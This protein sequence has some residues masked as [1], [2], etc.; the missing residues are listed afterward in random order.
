[1][2][3]MISKI[4]LM[5]RKQN[6]LKHFSFF[7]NFLSVVFLRILQRVFGLVSMYFLLK[8]LSPELYGQYQFILTAVTLFTFFAL[9]G[10]G[11]AIVQ[12]VARGYPGTYKVLQFYSFLS[13]LVG[14]V[15]LMFFSIWYYSS[16]QDANI[17]HGFIL[18]ALLFPFSKGLLQWRSYKTGKKLFPSLVFWEGITSFLINAG[19]IVGVFLVPGNYIVPLLVVFIIPGLINI[20]KTYERL[21]YLKGDNTCEEGSL[22]YSIQTTIYSFPTLLATHIEKILLFFFLSPSALAVFVL[23]QKIPELFRNLFQDLG[24]VLAPYLAERKSYSLKLDKALKLFALVAGLITIVISFTI[25]PWLFRLLFDP[26]YYEAIPYMIAMMISVVLGVH[27]N[28]RYR[29]IRSQMDSKSIRDISLI[30]ALTRILVA[31]ICIPLYGLYGA[32]ISIFVQQLFFIIAVN[33]VINKKY[34]IS[35]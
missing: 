2:R 7:K 35:S 19:I 16:E 24:A 6:C 3:K 9:S 15:I 18:A 23:A 30:I 20:Y 28:L 25:L 31:I 1:M 33:I 10:S 22:K 27:A 13:S 14:A 21:I 12:S 5:A 34:Q 32:V 4:F 26:T 11:N 8:A 29:F 17:L